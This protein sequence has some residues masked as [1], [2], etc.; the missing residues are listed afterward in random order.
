MIQVVPN[1]PYKRMEIEEDTSPGFQNP[2]FISPGFFI[3]YILSGKADGTYYYRVRGV[4]YYGNTTGW[5]EGA[6][7]CIVEMKPS[8]PYV[9]VPAAS[10]TGSFN[11]SWAQIGGA[12]GYELQQSMQP[13][14]SSS[15]TYAYSNAVQAVS[16]NYMPNGTFYYRVRGI[17]G[18]LKGPWS[19]GANG[20]TVTVI[21]TFTVRL[22]PATPRPTSVLAGTRK[23][24]VLQLQ[25]STD[26]VE[27][28]TLD[29]ITLHADGTLPEDSDVEAAYLYID[30]D[31]NG[32]VDHG[33][34]CL[35]GPCTF[36]ADNGTISFTGLSRTYPPN[37][38]DCLLVAYD[39]SPGAVFGDDFCLRLASAGD[40]DL[41]GALTPVPH[42][43]IL[44]V[45]GCTRSIGDFGSLHIEIDAAVLTPGYALPGQ[46]GVLILPLRITAGAGEPVRVSTLIL[47]SHATHIACEW[48][49]LC[50]YED[51]NR[52]SMF[53]EGDIML[54]GPVPVVPGSDMA[55]FWDLQQV[56]PINQSRTWFVT[57]HVSQ[58]VVQ[59]ST[60]GLA[61][62]S[63]TDFVAHG[64]WWGGA[65]QPT[66]IPFGGIE[67]VVVSAP[68]QADPIVDQEPA[69]GG[70][71][72]GASSRG[73]PGGIL[74]TGLLLMVFL[75]CWGLLRPRVRA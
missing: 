27:A 66:G 3:H 59:G 39:I 17:F 22:G 6:N 52:N 69:L 70:C 11:V 61:L 42:T 4:D 9:A 46:E 64:D 49:T 57:A 71:M 28:I 68:D 36:T 16:V 7:G 30:V 63:S 43:N 53:D 74:G 18:T 67:T 33:D 58:D 1:G 29:R 48:A 2:T 44:P 34:Y 23:V 47:R 37:T 26:Y 45:L 15:Q 13:D 62:E 24:P 5:T 25:V 51:A 35:A 8:P 20:C 31:R 38:G 19:A 54:R 32:Q 21:G 65:V 40:L 10:V 41:T 14:F 55:I 60:F 50:L 73:N 56:I 75:A 72:P 12:T